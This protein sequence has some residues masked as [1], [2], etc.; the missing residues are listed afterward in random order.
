MPAFPELLR[1]H[2]PLL[3][4]DSASSRIQAA[5]FAGGGAPGAWAAS[6]DEAGTG[7]FSCAESLGVPLRDVRGFVFCEGPG[8]ILGIRTAAMAIRTWCALEP[9]PVFAYR[10]L[11]LVAR[12]MPPGD[13]HVIADARRDSWH[14]CDAAGALTRVPAAE[15]R[16]RL[17]API[18]FRNW[19][20]MPEGAERVPYSVADLLP[21]AA[22][23]DLFRSVDAPDAF[24]HGDIAYATWT[25]RARAKGGL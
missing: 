13:F 4:L 3:L 2:A 15:L 9:R 7:I 22:G 21:L 16:G 8:S 5:F 25:P 17:I 12:T 24:T 1:A 18:G 10:S 19:T 11:E 6:D 14:A 23:A 20:P